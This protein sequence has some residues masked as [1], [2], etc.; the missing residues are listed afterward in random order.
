MEETMVD[1]R[2]MR[3]AI[4][5]NRDGLGEGEQVLKS[6]CIAGRVLALEGVRQAAVLF[7]YMHYRSEVRTRE[8]MVSLL[9][10]GHIV[11]VPVTVPAH[12]SLLAVRVTDPD[13]QV[14]PGYLGIPEPFPWLVEQQTVD[15]ALVD[16]VIVPGSVFDRSGGRLGYGGGY[17]DRFLAGAAPRAV[18]IGLAFEQQLVARVPLEPHDQEMDYVVSERQVYH[19]RRKKDAQNS[20]VQG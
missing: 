13:N 8:L 6:R 11:T 16:V 10:T 12:S 4:L 14:E 3:R 7:V 2:Q 1:R 19:C 9:S 18:R 5:K 20:S 15:P 17:Y